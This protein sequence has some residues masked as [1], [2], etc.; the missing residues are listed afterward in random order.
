MV[1]F[2]LL[3][4]RVEQTKLGVQE[5]G[6]QCDDAFRRRWLRWQSWW[7][8]CW[9][10]SASPAGAV[11]GGTF[12]STNKFANVGFITVDGQRWCSGTLYRTSSD[13][14]S[15]NLFMTAAHCTLGVTG[16]FAVTFDPAA[17][18]PS[19]VYIPGVAY[20]HPDY[21]QED[22][23]NNSLGKAAS[24]DVGV[25]V[26]SKTPKG[27]TLA[28]LPSIGLVDTLNPKT[29]RLTMVGYGIEDWQSANHWTYGPR[30]YKDVTILEGQR[31]ATGELY[32]KV[33]AGQCFGDSG[34]PQFVKGTSTIAAV[35]SWGQ[36]RVCSDHG[37][38]YRLDQA[39]ALNFLRNPTV[40]GVRS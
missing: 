39:S 16:Q 11:I 24:D 33:S 27:I 36:S 5:G 14:T 20:S 25:V 3:S 18:S 7:L 30:N 19:S 17:P 6:R 28:D 12:D 22:K 38:G 29:A 35:N 40:V 37:Y 31:T 15:S 23:F 26:L 1:A 9:G 4:P 2:F 34:G 8:R 13:Q 21:T 32:L 10:L